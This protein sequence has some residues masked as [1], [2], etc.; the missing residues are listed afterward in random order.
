MKLLSPGG[1]PVATI[2]WARE[3]AAVP[4][5]RIAA[6]TD[7]ARR[8]RVAMAFMMVCSFDMLACASRRSMQHAATLSRS[9]CTDI[10]G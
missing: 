4:A 8:Q 5:R 3:E 10:T 6:I 1:R 7:R 9:A 2:D